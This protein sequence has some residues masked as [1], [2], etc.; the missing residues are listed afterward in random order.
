M[1]SL[2]VLNALTSF[3]ATP[4]MAAVSISDTSAQIAANLNAL[5]AMAAAGKISA[6]T[7]S[8][9]STALSIT[10][11]QLLADSLVLSKISG[12]YKLAVSGVAAANLSTALANTKVSSVTVIDSAANFNANMAALVSAAANAKVLSITLSGAADPVALTAAQYSATL[13]A[14]LANFT[15]SVS[16]VSSANAAAVNANAKVA[17][18]SVLDTSA[19]LSKNIAALGT[20]ATG[21][22][23]GSITQSGTVSNL[24][25]TAAQYSTALTSKFSNFGATVSAVSSANAG[26]VLSDSKVASVAVSDS[27]A[28]IASRLDA[29]QALGSKVSSIT[30]TGTTSALSITA[31]QMTADA[32]A[33]AKIVGSYKLSVTNVAVSSVASLL[34][35]PVVSA[36][37][38]ADSCANLS[39]NIAALVTAASNSKLLS[40][41][42]TGPVTALALT[43]AQYTS[44]LTAKFSNF[45]ATVSGVSATNAAG[46]G[47]D[48][49]VSGLSVSDT[50]ANIVKNMNALAALAGGS[51]LSTIT[52]TGTV[53]AVALTAAQYSSALT[54]KF[55]NFT[56][57]VTAASATQASALAADSKVSTTSVS[58]T[59]ANIANNLDALQAM[60]SKLSSITQSGTAAALAISQA[61]LTSDAQ[62][63]AK[64][65]GP[66]TLALSGV[67]IGN[68]TSVLSNTH[69]VSVAIA[70]HCA[71]LAANWDA[72]Q[73][74]VGKI[75]G[76]TLNDNADMGITAVQLSSDAQVLA[77]IVGPYSLV[78]SDVL[79]ANVLGTLSQG[80]VSTL[81]VAD[82][83]TQLALNLDGLC[84]HTDQ[85]TGISMT[86]VLST[87]DLSGLQFASGITSKMAHFNVLVHD[88]SASQLQALSQDSIVTGISISDTAAEISA[89][90]DQLASAWMAGLLSDITV[91]DSQAVALSLTQSSWGL[92]GIMHNAAGAPCTFTV[93]DVSTADLSDLLSNPAIT[94]VYLADTSAN[95]HSHLNDLIAASAAGQLANVNFTDAPTA[96]DV[97]ANTALSAVTLWSV[98]PGAA[99]EITDTADTVL[100]NALGLETVFQTLGGNLAAIHLSDAPATLSLDAM[101]AQYC[102]DITHLLHQSASVSLVDSS[103]NVAAALDALNAAALMGD[104]DSITLSDVDPV[105]TLT[106]QQ[107]LNDS[108]ALALISQ[109]YTLSIV[110]PLPPTVSSEFTLID[111]NAITLDVAA[112][113]EAA[114]MGQ[115]AGISLDPNSLSV[116]A[117][118]SSLAFYDGSLTAL[119]AG[120]GLIITSGT[121]PGTSNSA[122]WFG[123]D[124]GMVGDPSL[125]KVVN[126]V[127]ATQSYD[128]SSIS[129]AFTVTDPNIQ[130]ITFNM[131]FGSDEYPE[132]VDAYVDIAVVLVNGVNVAYFN[133]DPMSPL[134]VIG[135]NLANNYYIDNM[136]NIDPNT[137]T[138]LP[139][140]TST[141]PIEYDGVSR[142]LTIVAAVQQ[143][144]NTIKIAIADTGDHVYD[145]GLFISALTPTNTPVP[146]INLPQTGTENDDTLTGKESADLLKG[147]GGDDVI[148]AAGGDDVVLGGDGNDQMFGDAGDDY[149]DGG[150]G[151]NIVSGGDGSD[152]M[153]HTAGLDTLDGGAG[154]DTLKVDHSTHTSGETFALLA[155][156]LVSTLADGS[157]ITQVEV[158]DFHAG[159]GNDTLTGNAGNDTLVGGDGT[160]VL[161]GGGGDDQI[162]GG[163]GQDTAVYS[164]RFA[165]YLV[166]KSG[167]ASYTIQDLRSG[168]NDGTDA[169]V[170]IESLQ[171]SD[172]LH[173]MNDWNVHGNTITG[174]NADN[175][176]SSATHAITHAGDTI[177]G[178]GGD[179]IIHAGDGSDTIDGGTGND[180][181]FGGN[182][183][184]VLLGGS[185]HD[186]ITGGLGA[187]FFVFTALSDSM[188][189][190]TANPDRT[191]VV[192]DFNQAQGDKIDL[193]QLAQSLGLGAPNAPW[194]LVSTFSA[195]A[196]QMVQSKAGDGFLL[197]IDTDGNGAGDFAVQIDCLVKLVQSDFIV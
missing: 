20:A 126:Q 54:A 134:S 87:L 155:D 63:L 110:D 64:I 179:D 144:V 159:S 84:A 42:E 57:T 118:V 53:A 78:V 2:S 48:T 18:F 184:D 192:L 51:K 39:A 194:L 129:F 147:L 10:G 138:A 176:I 90:L 171:F 49:K 145:S 186:E 41:S 111:P 32:A 127:F 191:D 180:K 132:W 5:N 160:N 58:D 109:P 107:S 148:H 94:G 81:S 89:A 69:V 139:G 157:T 173:Q 196:G 197:Q 47:A 25:L 1:A 185:G 60:G 29:L 50:A 141:L 117:G 120:Q 190:T 70:D 19:N 149:L 75:S 77:K 24:A 44:K 163:S 21:S 195:Q 93:A 137:G 105:L 104:L 8:T 56:A 17:S 66:Y 80:H 96:F 13:T 38:V 83:G 98:M 3:T 15:V 37:S 31:A 92:L 30:Q 97:D 12:S 11:S 85:I 193:S 14:K 115:A 61:Q 91:T 79:A 68:L 103:L 114:V 140:V 166:S 116:V 177:S 133:H 153:L 164:G 123:Q 143:G 165:D 172:S 100:A 181:L 76:I 131:V 119:G 189:S 4:S 175:N 43:A 27:S 106:T 183:N 7:S 33:L 34:A 150:V 45:T 101:T 71:H 6:I 9:L 28:N 174:T 65:S 161:C 73:S 36:V 35:N 99:L 146:G 135:S 16:G 130:G 59:S 121:M 162:I 26:A 158:L 88:A 22:K 52:E 167:D 67:L 62:A 112:Q 82:T 187:D 74:R 170:S 23:L 102:P 128:A 152:T 122:S 95:I 124:N 151:S 168:A 55:V 86:G 113:I 154:T 136:A 46:V 72:L 108:A 169:L 188:L 40:I 142:P 178:L 156:H 125:D 182:G